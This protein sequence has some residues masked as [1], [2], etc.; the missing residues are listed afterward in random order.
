[1]SKGTLKNFNL[2]MHI[3]HRRKQIICLSLYHTL[4]TCIYI[5][6]VCTHEYGLPWWLSSKESSC[7]AGDMGSIPGWERSPVKEMATHSS[8]LAWEIPLIEE[9]G[10]L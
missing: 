9:T 1:M 8:I 10:G 5:L 2:K 6:F 3:T 7:S 4:K